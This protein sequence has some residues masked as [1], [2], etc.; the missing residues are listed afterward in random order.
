MA[1][2]N[3]PAE[4]SLKPASTPGHYRS[5]SMPDGRAMGQG[6]TLLNM[7]QL[8]YGVSSVEVVAETALPPDTYDFVVRLPSGNREAF[9]SLLHER[10]GLVAQFEERQ[11]DA[12]VVRLGKTGDTKLLRSAGPQRSGSWGADSFKS[13]AATIGQMLTSIGVFNKVLLLDETGLTN[14][15]VMD[16]SW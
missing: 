11:V 4:L 13:D 1:L 5:I 6:A 3:G 7:A 10:F 2:Q 9:Q 15:Y 14:Q 16:L 8:A 12:V